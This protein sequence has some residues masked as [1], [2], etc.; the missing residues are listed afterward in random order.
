[1][2]T[3]I[4]IPAFNEVENIPNLVKNINNLGYDYLVINDCSTDSSSEIYDK[5]KLKHI[6]LSINLGLASVTQVGFKYALEHD[7]DSVIVVDGDGQHPPVYIKE[8]L[9]MLDKGYDYVVGSRFVSEKKPWSSRMLGSRLLCL[10]IFFKTGKWV[11]DP[12]S[13]MR[14]MGR[15]VIEDF[16]NSLNFVAEPDAYV[17]VIKRKY[18][19]CE[20]QV[21]MTERQ[22][23]VSYFKNPFKS[24]KFMFNVIM[25][26]IFIQ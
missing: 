21:T 19:F 22:A 4:I 8:L 6:D 23:G 25:S 18:K 12:T 1:M 17:H 13:G 24:I 5:L 26:I 7:Y 20:I 14:A 2:K 9:E 3:L 16:A 11:S 10:F 15:A